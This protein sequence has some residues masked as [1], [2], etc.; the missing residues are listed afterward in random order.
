ML[1]QFVI[2]SAAT[3]TFVR[4]VVIDALFDTPRHAVHGWLLGR[5]NA[6]ALKI[7]EGLA[8]SGCMAWWFSFG[9]IL[10]ADFNP[11]W[12]MSIPFPALLIPACRT[13]ALVF[14]IIIDPEED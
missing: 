1:T 6:V 14:A 11:W 9:S 2:F 7:H 12:Q 3:Y 8:C 13:G 5:R 10:V 4:F